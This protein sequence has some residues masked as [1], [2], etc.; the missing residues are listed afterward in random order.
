MVITMVL[1]VPVAIFEQSLVNGP[2]SPGMT[3]PCLSAG[4]ASSQP[5]Q[6]LDG[7]QLAEEEPA[8]VPFFQVSPV[9][10]QPLGDPARAQVAAFPPRLD[11]RDGSG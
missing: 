8:E 9:L 5:D 1:P 3:M 11:P 10:Q 4:G 6:R 7:F 2:P